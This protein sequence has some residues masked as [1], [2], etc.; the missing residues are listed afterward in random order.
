MT[1]YNP[2]RS[3]NGVAVKFPSVYKWK[4]E[5]LS[6]ADAGRTEDTI[7]DKM[8]IGQ[9][10]GIELQWNKVSIQEASTLLQQFNPEYV[11]V[12]YLDAMAGK[13]VTKTFYV[14]N[15]S[16]PLY[17]GELGLWDN[18]AFNLIGRSGV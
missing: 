3:I 2:I 10:V 14:G 16:A 4:L 7:M 18:I 13:Y 9:V 8:R 5:D 11:E 15:R 1:D 12:C 6:A 17:N